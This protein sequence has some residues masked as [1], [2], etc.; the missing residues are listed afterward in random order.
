[1]I[2]WCAHCLYWIRD[3]VPDPN[4]AGMGEISI[5]NITVNRKITASEA[6]RLLK[7]EIQRATTLFPPKGEL[8]A[9]AW[10]ETNPAAGSEE[11]I[12]L[13][14][15]SNF[16]IYSPKTKTAQ[17]EKQYDTS[18]QKPPQA[19]KGIKV[20]VSLE[21][22][23]GTDGRVRILGTTN[24]P[25][26]MILMT[27]LRKVG[28]KY[29]AQ[30]KVEVINGRISTTWFS[31]GGKAPPSG[32]YEVSISSPLPALQSVAVRAVIGQTGE[33]L[34]GPIRTSM[35][36]KMVDVTVKNLFKVF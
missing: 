30:D 16:L 8:M 21:L 11:M 13:P 35:G 27:D 33:N 31:D 29:F 2:L 18:K 26:G 23:R 20:D 1:M 4:G 7:E 28:A 34:S 14:D 22:E 32:A 5:I 25:H 10:L 24:L 6:E 17:T 12:K 3:S 19:G 15:G 36:S 9:Y